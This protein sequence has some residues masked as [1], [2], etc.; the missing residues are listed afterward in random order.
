MEKLPSREDIDARY[1][2]RLEDIYA[3]DRLW[4]EDYKK[5]DE[6]IGRAEGFK[7]KI[8]TD[9]L[10]DALKARD[11]AFMLVERLYSYAH[12]R[13]DED[14]TKA[15]YQGLTD[16]AMSLYAEASGRLSF[17]EPEILK[18]PEEELVNRINEDEDMRV[19]RHY[20]E[21]L[22]RQKEH[23]LDA[24]KE[25]M[26]AESQEVLSSPGDIYR[27]LT[28]ADIRFP[29]I[30]DESGKDVEL[31]KGR[32]SR[33]ISS[34]DRDVRENAFKVFHNTYGSYI[35]T[36]T[37]TTR[38][39]I[40][41]DIFNKNQRGFSSSLEAALFGD[42]IPVEVYDN[43][44]NSVHES[45]SLMHRYVLLRKKVLG[46]DEIHLYDMYV[47]MVRE[48]DREFTYEEAKDM[49]FEGLGALGDKYL[50]IVKEGFESGWIDVYE[51]RGKTSGG[52]SSWAYGVHP[53]ILL[54]YQGKLN[55]VFTLAHEMGHSVHTYY[56]DK[57]QPFIY[58]S[59]P[60][61]LAEIASTCNE[62]LL[63]N[64]LLDRASSK[65]ERKY[66]LNHFMDQFKSTL[67]RQT[68]FAE[69]EKITHG[70]AEA[71]EAITP[72]VLCNVYHDLNSAYFG[73]NAVIDKEIDYEWARIP[74]FY[75]SFYVYKY[76]TGFS[77][78][79]AI[80]QMIL[81]EGK[82]AVDRYIEFLKSGGSDYPMNILSRVGVD[83]TRPEPIREA[84]NFFGRL[85]DEFEKLI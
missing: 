25:R 22:I 3:D 9:N 39:N 79:I 2:W 59:Y 83:L 15:A 19:Y 40:K 84:L 62:A 77:A 34:F 27:M 70:M 41:A 45:L 75:N 6:L 24:D 52:Y 50:G 42:N 44:I 43:L 17:I 49:V 21:N 63:I 1:K 11:E 37:A 85:L 82:P 74:H 13:K 14:N 57:A 7:G 35:N 16:R 31:S 61:F 23:I 53:Y 51:T 28:D 18:L 48:Y 10:L 60:I 12:M 46:L 81:K 29:V 30:K 32:Y 36:I 58:K 69:F 76:A 78:A 66:L 56:S 68:M 47:P 8:T 20:I 71:G 67:Y 65:E 72:D 54:N 4:E 73:P 33:M 55:D 26:L 38:A 5:A 64:Y 80:S